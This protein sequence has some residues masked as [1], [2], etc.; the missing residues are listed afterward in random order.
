MNST[1]AER[2]ER[3]TALLDERT[4]EGEWAAG[5]TVRPCSAPALG[6]FRR[7]CV[8][9]HVRDAWICGDHAAPDWNQ[10]KACV[11]LDGGLSHGCPIS[12]TEVSA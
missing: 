3:G 12:I 2:A 11:E 7:A 8:H 1:V 6:Y 9:E 10:C 5:G 4:C